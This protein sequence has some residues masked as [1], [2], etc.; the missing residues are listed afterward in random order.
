MGNFAE[1][2]IELFEDHTITLIANG[3]VK[4]FYMHE[5]QRAG[6]VLLTFTP[7]GI[8]IQGDWVPGKYGMVSRESKGLYWFGSEKNERYLCSK[9]LSEEFVRKRAIEFLRNHDE[10]ELP[11]KAS[12][13]D[14]ERIAD[15]LEAGAIGKDAYGK[16][17]MKLGYPAESIVGYDYPPSK[18][19][20][21]CAIQQAFSEKFQDWLEENEDVLES[22]DEPIKLHRTDE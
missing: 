9:F 20:K 3:R 13:E 7:E 5:G 15:Q 19:S 10:D 12:M 6:S 16:K 22:P 2:H 18:A 14:F 11:R 4:S 1:Q 8:A 21:L 17:L